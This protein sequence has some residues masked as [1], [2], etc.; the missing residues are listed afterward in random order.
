MVCDL[1]RL[2]DDH[3]NMLIDIFKG[4][5]TELGVESV[6]TKCLY[7]SVTILYLLCGMKAI[8]GS[9]KCYVNNVKERMSG[10][11]VSNVENVIQ[12]DIEEASRR[13]LS[14]N[15]RRMVYFMMITNSELPHAKDKTREKAFFP[16]HVFVIDKQYDRISN[17]PVYRLYQSYINKYTLQ[18]FSKKKNKNNSSSSS[19]SSS[20]RKTR[21]AMDYTFDEMKAFLSKLS[22]LLNSKVW[23][24]VNVDFWKEFTHVSAN[25]MKGFL[26]Q[27]HIYFCFNELPAIRCKEGLLEL[28]YEKFKDGKIPKEHEKTVAKLVRGVKDQDKTR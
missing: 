20:S 27:P 3:F 5:M 17:E 1:G 7:T 24:Q 4:D 22:H 25:Y 14:N 12:K 18:E 28:L 26:I 21:K 19:S 15:K 8:E 11:T 16:G 23:T 13:I 10:L 9:L 6:Y 2:I